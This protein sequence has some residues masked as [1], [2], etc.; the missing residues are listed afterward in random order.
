MADD[1]RILEFHEPLQRLA[2]GHLD[3]HL[4]KGIFVLHALS[5]LA[6]IWP[7]V[8]AYSS[9]PLSVSRI[10]DNKGSIQAHKKPLVGYQYRYIMVHIHMYRIGN[11]EMCRGGKL[12]TNVHRRSQEVTLL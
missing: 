8:S 4:Q 9:S 2:E 3:K 5:M 7:H 12:C 11:R 10:Q 6:A 1:L